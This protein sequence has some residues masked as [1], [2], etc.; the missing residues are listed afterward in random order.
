MYTHVRLVLINQCLLKVAF[1]MTKALNGQS[2]PKQSFHSLHLSML[3][4]KPCFSSCLF[5]SF[6]HSLFYFK[7]YKISTDDDDDDDDDDD[8]L[9]LWYG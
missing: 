1:S 3:F 9:F 2:S 4:G 5:S 8:E 6:S 7:L